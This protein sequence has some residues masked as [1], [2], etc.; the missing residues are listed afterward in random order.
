MF[1]RVHAYR[2]LIHNPHATRA[3]LATYAYLAFGTPDR[4]G[5]H[6]SEA[7]IAG[8][9]RQ[10]RKTVRAAL[11]H[12]AEL[13]AVAIERKLAGARVIGTLY[14]FS[15]PGDGDSAPLH[16]TTTG[17][18]TPHHG[19]DRP[20]SKT[21]PM[22]ETTPPIESPDS[23]RTGSDVISLE[24]EQLVRQTQQASVGP[25][26]MENARRAVSGA[27]ERAGLDR[28]RAEVA[29]VRG[30]GLFSY[31]IR[32]RL[33]SL[34]PPA[35]TAAPVRPDVPSQ[36]KAAPCPAVPSSLANRAIDLMASSDVGTKLRW[37]TAASTAGATAR[38]HELARWV[39]RIAAEFL[40]A[41]CRW[42]WER[43]TA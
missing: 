5:C 2:A 8:G 34:C 33:E 27:I 41:E 32:K 23:N 35:T 17:E 22:G 37:H 3:D 9:T 21:L 25:W 20:P 36:A 24:I 30:A 43:L 15:K 40:Q 6:P 14:T 12:L 18:T 29:E 1:D 7:T 4:D 10:D 31:E 42:E 26:R 19:S 39:P 38:M 11:R 16:P 13:G 28:V